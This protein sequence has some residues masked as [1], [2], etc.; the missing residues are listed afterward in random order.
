VK[1]KEVPQL[2]SALIMNSYFQYDVSSLIWATMMLCCNDAIILKLQVLYMILCHMS[3]IY[4]YIFCFDVGDI[5][6]EHRQ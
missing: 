5:S 3:Y 2:R 4:I 6:N 1:M